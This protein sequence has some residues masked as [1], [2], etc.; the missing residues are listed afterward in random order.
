MGFLHEL[1]E[2][3][4]IAIQQAMASQFQDGYFSYAMNSS[5]SPFLSMSENVVAGVVA[6]CADFPLKKTL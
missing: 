1:D 6:A 4:P 5:H 2:A 3:I